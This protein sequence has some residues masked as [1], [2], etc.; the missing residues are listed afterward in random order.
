MGRYIALRT[1]QGILVLLGAIVIAFALVNVSGDAVDALVGSVGL[2]EETARRLKSA[3]GFDDP[4]LTRFGNYFVGV[5]QGD[6]GTSFRSSRPALAM[7]LEALRYTLTLVAGAIAVST[8]VAVP[9]A[10]MSVLRR[11]SALEVTVRRTFM[12]LQGLPEFFLGLLLV[13]LFAVSL[14]WL[15]SFGVEGPES[16]V[17]PILAL[18]VPLFSTLT[19]LLRSQLVDIM[20]S[21]LVTALRARGLT[22][23]EIV[24]GH[25][26]RGALPP[27]I[28]YLALQIG[29]LIGG[30]LLVEVVFG[31]PGIGQLAITST[32]YRDIAVIEAVV[33]VIAASYVVLNLLADLAVYALD[34]RV[35]A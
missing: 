10:V 29:W 6:F 21:E 25:A 33:V 13:L 26:L 30:A 20:G 16:Y 8:L 27:L 18:S 28:A 35:R 4:V 34:P 23:R 19:R 7:V 15:P 11:G 31:V 3:Y 22:E 24:F 14:Q 2:P 5:I 12:V 17:L 1:G 32:Q 9:T